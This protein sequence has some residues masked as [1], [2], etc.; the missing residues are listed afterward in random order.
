MS[1]LDVLYYVVLRCVVLCRS[2]TMQ[3]QRM[4]KCWLL[5][6]RVLSL[7]S[8]SSSC[9]ITWSTR[10]SHILFS[11]LRTECSPQSHNNV[12]E[13]SNVVFM[14]TVA[15]VSYITINIQ[16]NRICLLQKYNEMKVM[17]SCC[18]IAEKYSLFMWMFSNVCT[19]TSINC[20][21]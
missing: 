19:K 5:L 15:S 17:R 18:D 9:V 21:S 1:F 10:S 16:L 12:S 3:H 11:I 4:N 13:L 2:P 20:S 6:I 8:S 14:G 7:I